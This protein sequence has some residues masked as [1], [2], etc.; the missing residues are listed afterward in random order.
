[1]RILISGGVGYAGSIV[2][3]DLIAAGH[4]VIMLDKPGHD[5]PSLVPGEVNYIQGDLGDT[6]FVERVFTRIRILRR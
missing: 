5:R 6:A 4:D 2:A 3:E 1:M